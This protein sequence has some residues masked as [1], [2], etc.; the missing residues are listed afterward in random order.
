M[1]GTVLGRHGDE[2]SE[3]RG[4]VSFIQGVGHNPVQLPATLGNPLVWPY[5]ALRPFI[6]RSVACLVTPFSGNLR[7]RHG[8]RHSQK[9]W[10]LSPQ[11]APPPTLIRASTTPK[12]NLRHAVQCMILESHVFN[13][14]VIGGVIL[15]SPRQTTRRE[16]TQHGTLLD[17]T[18][19]CELN[20]AHTP[21]V[22]FGST[23]SP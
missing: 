13:Q 22:P 14:G 9:C 18:P 19:P 11:P 8:P 6:F 23:P 1:D 2:R 7:Y 3:L 4:R 10:K 21:S 16:L 15:S 17:V 5:K 20:D 12:L